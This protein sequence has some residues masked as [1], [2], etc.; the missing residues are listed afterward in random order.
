MSS[1]DSAQ[2]PMS[3]ASPAPYT[4]RESLLRCWC[5]I[6]LLCSPPQ[7]RTAPQP[8]SAFACFSAR[9]EQFSVACA[10]PLVVCNCTNSCF[11]KSQR[12]T[13]AF[14]AVA[15]AQTQREDVSSGLVGVPYLKDAGRDSYPFSSPCSLYYFTS[16]DL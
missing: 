14:Y 3:A 7:N 8:P 4:A 11:P 5:H 12:C 16:G 1:L 15:C 2:A 13:Q 10:R 9:R 6:W